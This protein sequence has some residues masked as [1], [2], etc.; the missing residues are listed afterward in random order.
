MNLFVRRQDNDLFK[1]LNE[2]Q[3]RIFDNGM[4]SE[5]HSAG[6]VILESTQAP[7]E[8]LVLQSGELGLYSNDRKQKIG[9]IFEGEMVFELF[10]VMPQANI[11]TLI[12][13]KDSVIMKVP[14]VDIN[15][16]C[17]M[18]MEVFVRIH[19]AINDSLC[20]KNISLTH[21]RN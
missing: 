13:E 7:T 18:D 4:I 2:A 16:F 11:F 6:T 8:I 21:R 14:F 5:V 9:C 15:R 1:Y 12:A 3:I 20:L 17:S 10:Y 19:A